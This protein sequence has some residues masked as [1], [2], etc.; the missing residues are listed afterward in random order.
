[1]LECLKGLKFHSHDLVRGN[2]TDAQKTS[3][4]RNITWVGK[5]NGSVNI[6]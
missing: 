5:R 6:V 4:V 1:M 3:L 2:V